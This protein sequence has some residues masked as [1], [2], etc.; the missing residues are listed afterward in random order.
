MKITNKRLNIIGAIIL[1]IG[2][3]VSSLF[4]RYNNNHPEDPVLFGKYL[5]IGIMIL[6]L[7]LF[8][9]WIKEEK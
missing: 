7:F 9:P 1:L 2:A 6:A 5:G 8:M 3:V 4:I